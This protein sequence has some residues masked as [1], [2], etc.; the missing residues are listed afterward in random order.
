MPGVLGVVQDGRF[1]AVVAQREEQAI[2]ARDRALEIATWHV[3]QSLPDSERIFDEL[4]AK[5]ARTNEIQDG[6]A[7]EE[8]TIVP[9]MAAEPAPAHRATYFRPFQMHASLGPSAALAYWQDDGLSIWSHSQ[10]PFVLRDALAQVLDVNIEAI[11]VIHAEG[12]GCYGHNGADDVALDAA[13]AA[14]AVLGQPVLMKWTRVDEHAWEPYGSAMVMKLEVGLD[15]KWS[16][17][18]MAPRHLE[19]CAFDASRHWIG[20]IRLVG[21]LAIGGALRATTVSSHGRLP[22]RRASQCRSDLQPA[23][24]THLAPFR[25]RQSLCGCLPC[26][27]WAHTPTSSPSNHSWTSWLSPPAP[28]R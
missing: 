8:V 6:V 2:W 27:A 10:A 11:R 28:T 18:K 22:L 25:G 1:L 3:D 17:S 24:Q 23:R 21:I 19:L 7:Q 16:D 15:V 12:A 5:P 9:D 14:R 20:H 13:L 26:A 4:L